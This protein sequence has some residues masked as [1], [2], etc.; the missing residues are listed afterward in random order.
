MARI[1]Y[2]IIGTAIIGQ[3]DSVKDCRAEILSS[4]GPAKF[5]WWSDD[6]KRS[7]NARAVSKKTKTIKK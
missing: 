6:G 3:C 5:E 1:N 4:Y 7:G 2:R